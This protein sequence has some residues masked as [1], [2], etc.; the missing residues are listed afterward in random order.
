MR[1]GHNRLKTAGRDPDQDK[2][3]TCAARLPTLINLI[4]LASAQLEAA[5]ILAI[6]WGSSQDP[7]TGRLRSRLSAV[8]IRRLADGGKRRVLDTIS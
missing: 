7:A 8:R 3:C 4:H 2:S 1:Q 6:R 5:I